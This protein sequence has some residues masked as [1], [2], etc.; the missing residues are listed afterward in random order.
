MGAVGQ[1]AFCLW[2]PA[3]KEETP[4]LNLYMETF[5][6]MY[7]QIQH[8]A[9][10]EWFNKQNTKERIFYKQYLH[11]EHVSNS[12]GFVVLQLGVDVLYF[13]LRLLPQPPFF[14]F[15]Q[16]CGFHSLRLLDL[17]QNYKQLQGR[18]VVM[19]SAE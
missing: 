4:L 13:R 7:Y 12:Q 3:G 1:E 11:N 14:C 19:L 15:R 5:E 17:Q 10:L 9:K 18:T 2:R 6:K 8:M 16:D